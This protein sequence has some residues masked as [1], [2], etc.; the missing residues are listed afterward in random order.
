LDQKDLN[1]GAPK[2][3]QKK[4]NTSKDLQK[5]EL[6]GLK[7]EWNPRT[8]KRLYIS[9]HIRPIK[10][11]PISIGTISGLLMIRCKILKVL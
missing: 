2:R 5:N 9:T 7:K 6:K 8:K 11:W 1:G 10:E 4:L 3:P